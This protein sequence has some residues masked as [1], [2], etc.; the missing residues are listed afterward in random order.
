MPLKVFF[1]SAYPNYQ[2]N[3]VLEH[4]LSKSNGLEILSKKKCY[5]NIRVI[6]SWL[7]K[8]K[9]HVILDAFSTN[10]IGGYQNFKLSKW[11]FKITKIIISVEQQSIILS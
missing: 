6:E 9:L 2:L 5:Q 11:W 7:N 1:L 3:L 4:V 10:L 8:W